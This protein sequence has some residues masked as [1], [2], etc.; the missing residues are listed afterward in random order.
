MLG[1]TE[2]KSGDFSEWYSQVITKSHMIEYYVEVSGCYILRPWAMSI[3]DLIKE[4]IDGEIKKIGVENCYFPCF[5]SKA[6]LEREKEHVEVS[7][8]NFINHY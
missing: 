1:I 8:S 3:W 2:P 4:Y 5:V 6:A 7:L